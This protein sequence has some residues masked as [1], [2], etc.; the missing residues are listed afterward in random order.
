MTG[1]AGPDRPVQLVV[2][3]A[4]RGDLDQHVAEPGRGI[5]HLFVD[6]PIDAGW[7]VDADGLH[8]LVSSCVDAVLVAGAASHLPADF[9][10]MTE[11]RQR[12]TIVVS[13]CARLASDC[14]ALSA[15]SAVRDG[16]AR[17]RAPTA[18][19][20]PCDLRAPAMLA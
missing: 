2:R 10:V 7:F 19:E 20:R 11:R 12:E 3:D 5:G 15:P 4:A 14:T 17:Y 18:S 9:R 8:R 16:H 13:V 6:K 1:P